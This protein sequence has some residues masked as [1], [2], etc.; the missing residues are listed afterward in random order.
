VDYR[1]RVIRFEWDDA[2]EAINIQQRGISFSE[3]ALAVLDRNRL[4]LFDADHSDDEDRWTIIGMA[5]TIS[6]IL[7]VTITERM[8]GEI[9]R[10]IS[11]RKANASLRALYLR[12]QRG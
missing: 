9:I 10:I 5:G 7:R 2:K 12:K 1:S 11:A 6:V 8:N 3:A 4:E